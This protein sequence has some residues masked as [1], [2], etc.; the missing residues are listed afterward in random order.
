ML[1]KIFESCIVKLSFISPVGIIKTTE[2]SRK[3]IR[4]IL[5]NASHSINNCFTNIFRFFPN[6]IPMTTFRNYKTM[7]FRK[8]G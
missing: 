8:R 4:I 5:L 7:I 2:H 3:S 6:I 1:N